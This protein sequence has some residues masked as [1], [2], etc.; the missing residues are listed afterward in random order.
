MNV[1]ADTSFLFSLYVIDANTPAAHAVALKLRPAFVLTPLH[2]LEL[3]NAIQLAVFRGHIN[4]NQARAARH[5]FELDLSRWPLKPL[6]ADA[7]VRA[8]KLAERYTARQGTRSLD[9][10]H[11]ASAAVLRAEAFLTFDVR[12][13]RLA[14]AAGL[15]LAH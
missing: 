5:D 10:L 3:V 4:A 6:P 9:I 1:Y 14:K 11:V 7:F 8:I 2:E 15:R 12:Q 13:R